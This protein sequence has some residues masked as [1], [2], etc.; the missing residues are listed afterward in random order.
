MGLALQTTLAVEVG[1]SDD[2]IAQLSLAGAICG[3]TGS[4]VGGLISDRIGHRKTL[5]AYIVLT[6]LPT[7]ALAA[8]MHRS[9]WIMPVDPSTGVEAGAALLSAF[10]W[11]T[12]SYGFFSGLAYGTR[13]AI[14]MQVCSPKVAA[15]QFTAY[16]ALSNL[17]ISYSAAWQGSA[18][19]RLGYPLTLGLDAIAGIVCIGILPFLAPA[20][21]A[22]AGESAPAGVS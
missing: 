2:Q 21:Q 17:A 20:P 9:G 3:A 4:V 13:M 16:M 11:G 8:V 5:A 15:T 1:L 12:I 22:D 10:W 18:V 19:E 7:L 14:F 6:T